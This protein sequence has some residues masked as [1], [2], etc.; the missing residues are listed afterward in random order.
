MITGPATKECSTLLAV[1]VLAL[2]VA[3]TARAH[4]AASLSGLA[5]PTRPYA[6]GS[7]GTGL[8]LQSTL[9]SP[10]ERIAVINGRTFTLGDRVGGAEIVGIRPYGVVLRRAG[11]QTVLPLLPTLNIERR[12]DDILPSAAKR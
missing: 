11:R 2:L 9:V 7:G 12:S 1:A 5:D 10:L 4:A 6:A 3:G 8:V